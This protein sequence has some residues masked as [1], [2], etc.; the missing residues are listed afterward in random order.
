[1][2]GSML[3][4]SLLRGACEFNYPHTKEFV[5]LYLRG[6]F[7]ICLTSNNYDCTEKC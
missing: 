6:H 1:M 3:A 4:A 5:F 2:K 7:S